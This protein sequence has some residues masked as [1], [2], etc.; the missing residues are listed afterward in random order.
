MMFRGI[1]DDSERFPVLVDKEL[2]IG[3]RVEEAFV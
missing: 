1:V 2:A 3:V